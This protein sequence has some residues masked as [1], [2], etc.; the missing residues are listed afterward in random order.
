MRFFKW[1][2]SLFKKKPREII[3]YGE[4]PTER[5]TLTTKQIM[6]A[7]EYYKKNTQRVQLIIQDQ[8]TAVSVSDIE[9]KN[10]PRLWKAGHWLW[11]FNKH[12]AGKIKVV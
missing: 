11:F 4:L 10:N 2:L 7:I 9:H 3:S 8:Y 5:E 1:I 12:R 6:K